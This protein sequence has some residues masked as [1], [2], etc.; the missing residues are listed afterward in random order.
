MAGDPHR[1]DEHA[2]EANEIGARH[3][4]RAAERE[5][6]HLRE[7]AGEGESAATPAILIGTW[8]AI[9]LPL[10]AIVIALAVGIAYLVTS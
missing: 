2:H 1:A 6:E 9:L 5:L 7:I 4:L 10:V 8:I 3:P